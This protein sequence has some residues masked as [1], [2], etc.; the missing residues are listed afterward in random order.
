[1]PNI[2]KIG[3]TTLVLGKKANVAE[4]VKHL[5]G[6]VEIRADYK[7]GKPALDYILE[8]PVE[9]EISTVPVNRF[10][11]EPGKAEVFGGDFFSSDRRALKPKG[12]E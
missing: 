4:L 2:I 8:H 7:S 10:K 3:H 12:G 11:V 1:M 9:L 6:A 5:Q